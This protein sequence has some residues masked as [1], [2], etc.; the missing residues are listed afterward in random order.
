ME[1]DSRLRKPHL[2]VEWLAYVVLFKDPSGS[3]REVCDRENKAAPVID[4]VSP[5]WSLVTPDYFH[6]GNS[7]TVSE[8]A[9]NP[10]RELVNDS[11]CVDRLALRKSSSQF[12][13]SLFCQVLPMARRVPG[14]RQNTIVRSMC[15]RQ[16]HRNIS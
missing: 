2:L 10:V 12:I 4:S 13:E 8:D 3:Q 7:S 9:N 5:H 1:T 14:Y 6:T 16:G 15:P 11:A